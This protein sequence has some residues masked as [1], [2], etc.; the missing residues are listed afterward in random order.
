MGRLAV[1]AVGLA[2]V[3]LL[4][5]CLDAER[6]FRDGRLQTLC[7][8]TIPVC[9]TFASCTLRE[10]EFVEA[11]FPGGLKVVVRSDFERAVGVVRVLLLDPRFAGSEF[12]MRMWS[13]ACADFD[14]LRIVDQNIFEIARPDN[15]LEAELELEGRGDHLVEVFSDAASSYLLTVALFE[16]PEDAQEP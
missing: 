4:G 14:E 2:A 1:G 5:G 8:Q 7:E 6:S 13:N 11:S 10:D 12:Q 16:R 15:V 3:T 9:S